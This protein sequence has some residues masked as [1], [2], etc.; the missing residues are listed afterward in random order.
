MT[1]IYYELMFLINVCI[2][3]NS[4]FYIKN[5]F[6]QILITKH[7]FYTQLNIF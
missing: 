1:G 5:I 6:L 4:Y 7:S 3:I 2:I